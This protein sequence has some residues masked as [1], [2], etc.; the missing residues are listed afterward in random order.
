MKILSFE[1]LSDAPSVSGSP[2][3]VVDD[4]A[5][6]F[7]MDLDQETQRGEGGTTSFVLD[8]LQLEVAVG[9]S[10]CLYI[11]GYSP[12]IKWRGASLSPLI[13]Q[14]GSLRA[15]CDTPLVCGVA[16]GLEELLPANAW[17][18]TNSGWFCMGNK[19]I[20]SGAEAVEFATCCLA[21]VVGR[22]LSSLWIR[23]E[24]WKEVAETFR[25]AQI[26]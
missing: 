1:I 22:Q 25:V 15:T 11:W 20:T 26:K 5:F 21:V 17:F 4:H 7:Q 19:E 2:R 3:Y 18:D 12:M 8:T 14:P 13:A 16:I 10:L 24:N 23:P 9:S 6:D